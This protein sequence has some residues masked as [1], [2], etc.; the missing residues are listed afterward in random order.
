MLEYIAI[1]SSLLTMFFSYCMH[2]K[3]KNIG[4]MIVRIHVTHTNHDPNDEELS[5][6]NHKE[7]HHHWW[8]TKTG[9]IFIKDPRQVWVVYRASG[10]RPFIPDKSPR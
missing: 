9:D 8:N 2:I 1:I 7:Y 4:S 6:Y 3:C 5:K 10:C